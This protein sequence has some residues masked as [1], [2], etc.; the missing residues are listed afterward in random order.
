VQDIYIVDIVAYIFNIFLNS[1][2]PYFR[3]I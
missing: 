1:F 2:R 3:P